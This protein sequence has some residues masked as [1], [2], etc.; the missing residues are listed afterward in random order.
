MK[1]AILASALAL[2]GSPPA[3]AA[4]KIG[5]SCSGTETVQ[6]GSQAPQTVPYAIT[7]SA[8]LAAKAY[9]YDKCGPDQTYA[10]SD[11]TPAL[12]KLAD[13]D[14]GSQKRRMTFD[15]RSAR[16]TDYQAFDAGLGPVVRNATATCRAAPFH[17]PAP[18][19]RAQT[20]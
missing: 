8:D 18:L 14:R 10:I 16:L 11:S 9:C 5:E 4:D 19:A 2:V 17:E 7:F 6:I 20:H 15:R 1:L 13:L 3:Y 12:V